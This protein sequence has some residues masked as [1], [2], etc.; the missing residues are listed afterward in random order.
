MPNTRKP[1]KKIEFFN[2]LFGNSTK[3]VYVC[4]IIVGEA[5]VKTSKPIYKEAGREQ[6]L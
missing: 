5:L 2:A 4:V 6:A 3:L 1:T